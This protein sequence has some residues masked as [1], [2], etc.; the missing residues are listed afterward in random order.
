MP[1]SAV[2]AHRRTDAR[3]FVRARR[4]GIRQRML[5]HGIYGKR[6]AIRP[7]RW[8][9][10]QQINRTQRDIALRPIDLLEI[11]PALWPD[12][13]PLPINPVFEHT[14]PYAGA[15]RAD[16]LA[17]IRAAMREHGAD[18]HFLSTLDD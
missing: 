12:R 14:L 4:A 10:F 13:P 5:K 2:F 11:D 8:V 1:V 17:R 3:E 9:D 18:W 15:P 7:Q 6:R 16:K